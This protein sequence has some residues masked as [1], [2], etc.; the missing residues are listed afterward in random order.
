MLKTEKA[1]QEMKDALERGHLLPESLSDP[2]T[3]GLVDSLMS[4]LVML[5][6]VPMTWEEAH[7]K[8]RNRSKLR[9]VDGKN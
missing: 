4:C 1:I 8:E 9:V 6:H 7:R 3:C 2:Y 5:G